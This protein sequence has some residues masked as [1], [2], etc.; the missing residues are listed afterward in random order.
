MSLAQPKQID[1]ETLKKLK[2]IKPHKKKKKKRTHSWTSQDEEHANEVKA[3]VDR[4]I[5]M[6]IQKLEN[7]INNSNKK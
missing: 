7:F 2:E 6:K 3:Y 5:D 1:A 4:N